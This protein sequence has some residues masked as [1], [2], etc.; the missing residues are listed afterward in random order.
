MLSL[1]C[2]NRFKTNHPTLYLQFDALVDQARRQSS[3]YVILTSSVPQKGPIVGLWLLEICYIV[4]ENHA[5]NTNDS[6]ELKYRNLKL[7]Y[8]KGRT[9]KIRLNKYY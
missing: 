2:S 1:I 9:I 6:S 5:I 3:F 8:A 4:P 7:G